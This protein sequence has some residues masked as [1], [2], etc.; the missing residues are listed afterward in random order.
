MESRSMVQ[1]NILLTPPLG[2]CPTQP[3][4]QFLLAWEHVKADHDHPLSLRATFDEIVKA[5]QIPLSA[6]VAALIYA[7]RV[8]SLHEMNCGH[9]LFVGCMLLASKFVQDVTFNNKFW[10]DISHFSLPFLNSLEVF[11]LQILRCELY[12]H[13][14]E[15][16]AWETSYLSERKTR[17]TTVACHLTPHLGTQFFQA[18]TTPALPFPVLYPTPKPTPNP[19]LNSTSQLSPTVVNSLGYS[20]TFH[21]QLLRRQPIIRRYEPYFLPL[22]SLPISARCRL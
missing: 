14:D 6:V 16:L 8:S 11:L 20:S 22:P 10:A 13:P 5:T 1:P 12:I 17:T 3:L 21:S 7:E 9:C 2:S 18:T 4:A 15:Y 19:L